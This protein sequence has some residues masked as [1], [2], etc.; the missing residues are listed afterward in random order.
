M[1]NKQRSL[2][3]WRLGAITFFLTLRP[4]AGVFLLAAGCA[5]G[6]NYQQPDIAAPSVW[7]EAQQTGV[8]SRAADLTQWWNAFND[9]VLDS[10]IERGVRSNLDLRIAEAR[11]REARASRAVTAAGAWPTVDLS[12]SYSRNRASA[13]AVGA[14]AQGAV[15][16]PRQG[17]N[18][19]Q[20]FFHSGFDASWEIDIFG[21]V[22]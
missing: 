1:N 6:P 5:V 12:G 11:V 16:V 9:P 13:N 21:R 22:R 14:P 19:E 17:A 18:L 10:L 4:L 15:A 8:D 3:F 7:N 20:D 2:R